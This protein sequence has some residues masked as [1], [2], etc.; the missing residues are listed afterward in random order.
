[1][2]KESIYDLYFRFQNEYQKKFHNKKVLVLLQ[3][4]SFYEI[5]GAD[6]EYEKQG[7]VKTVCDDIGIQLSHKSK[8]RDKICIAQLQTIVRMGCANM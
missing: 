7:N 4:G 5:Y 2:T 6:N 8:E 3:V 1:M